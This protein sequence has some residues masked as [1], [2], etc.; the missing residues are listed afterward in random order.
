MN[1]QLKSETEARIER[2]IK[3]G[4]YAMPVDVLLAGLQ[5]LEEREQIRS[6]ELEQVREKIF[7]GLQQLDRGEGLDGEE[8]SS[9]LLAELDDQREPK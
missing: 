7:T 9:A 1:L 5:L 8:V 4:K 6:A 3:T 2:R